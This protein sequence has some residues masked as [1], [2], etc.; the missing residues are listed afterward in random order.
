[1]DYELQKVEKYLDKLEILGKN[2]KLCSA[3]RVLELL[4]FDVQYDL[5]NNKHH[6]KGG[7][8]DGK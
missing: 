7:Y 8:C 4:G 6:L 5:A 2:D 1:M 3:I